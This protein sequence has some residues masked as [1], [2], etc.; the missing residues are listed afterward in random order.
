MHVNKHGY[1]P[2][3]HRL[4]YNLTA[5]RPIKQCLGYIWATNNNQKKTMD[6]TGA[7]METMKNL[8]VAFMFGLVVHNYVL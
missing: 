6:A 1:A 7:V 3:L 4:D 2:G 5:Y 8:E